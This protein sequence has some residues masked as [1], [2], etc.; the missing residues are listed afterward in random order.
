M[1]LSINLDDD[2]YAMARAHAVAERISISKAVNALLR[3]QSTSR[4]ATPRGREHSASYLSPVT[5]I[6]VSRGQRPV[7]N[8]DA[9]RL[10]EEEDRC[11]WRGTTQQEDK[12]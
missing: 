11:H 6:R 7:T 8:E 1:R 4:G 3:S 12:P 2:L 9:K 5:G 10:E